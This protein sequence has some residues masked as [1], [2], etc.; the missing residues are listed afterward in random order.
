[1]YTGFSSEIV[2]NYTYANFHLP[3]ITQQMNT[4]PLAP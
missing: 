4:E 2:I 1:M 3:T